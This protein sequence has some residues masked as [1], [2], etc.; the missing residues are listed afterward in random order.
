MAGFGR[1][2]PEADASVS[3]ADENDDVVAVGGFLAGEGIV[4]TAVLLPTFAG[5]LPFLRD[6]PVC[7]ATLSKTASGRRS[8]IEWKRSRRGRIVVGSSQ[9]EVMVRALL[10]TERRL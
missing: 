6:I 4:T 9:S 1:S 3:P 5:L 8:D 10:R 7:R 2:G